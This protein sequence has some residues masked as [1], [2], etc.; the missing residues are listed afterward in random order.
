MAGCGY[1]CPDC[2]G[3]G[4]VGLERCSYCNDTEKEQGTLAEEETELSK[5]CHAKKKTTANKSP[6]ELTQEEWLNAVHNGPCCGDWGSEYSS[7]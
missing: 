1:V 7:E 3:Q 4:Y 2:E 6:N 5:A